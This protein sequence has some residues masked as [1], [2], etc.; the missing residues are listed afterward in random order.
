MPFA[1]V[2]LRQLSW[3][4]SD[5]DLLAAA[6]ASGVGELRL[7]LCGCGARPAEMAAVEF[8]D[9]A[10]ER[11]SA[12]ALHMRSSAILRHPVLSQLL[13]LARERRCIP[14]LSD[15]FF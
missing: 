4:A 3:R 15:F 1:P 13:C 8:A 6:L 2:L 5:V 12:S 9:L 14:R 11:S 7:I 10:R